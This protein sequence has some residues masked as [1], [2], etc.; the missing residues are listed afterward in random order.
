MFPESRLGRISLKSQRSSLRRRSLKFLKFNTGT[1]QS[2]GS[3]RCR[4]SVL[5]STLTSLSQN[6][7]LLR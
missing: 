6:T 5:K 2:R 1:S 3:L 4:K 7:L